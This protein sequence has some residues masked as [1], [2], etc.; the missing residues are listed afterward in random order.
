MPFNGDE[1]LESSPAP[2][3]FRHGQKRESSIAKMDRDIMAKVKE[4]S[5]QWQYPFKQSWVEKFVYKP[6]SKKC[7]AVTNAVLIG[8]SVTG[9]AL[10]GSDLDVAIIVDYESRVGLLAKFRKI[11]E[12][13]ETIKSIESISAKVPILR[14]LLF[15]PNFIDPKTSKDLIFKSLNLKG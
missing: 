10:K 7:R 1:T 5:D 15:I 9:I 12:S 3:K 4:V 8:S 2:R 13:V 11:L 14:F 6:L